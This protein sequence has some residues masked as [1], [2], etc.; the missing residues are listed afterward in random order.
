MPWEEREEGRQS[1]GAIAAVA[2]SS[3]AS[4]IVDWAVSEGLDGGPSTQ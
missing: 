4:I 3:E 2:S 1:G